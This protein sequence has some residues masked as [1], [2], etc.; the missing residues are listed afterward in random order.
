[1]SYKYMCNVNIFDNYS[2]RQTAVIDMLFV[3]IGCC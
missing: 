1:M 2:I 3:V